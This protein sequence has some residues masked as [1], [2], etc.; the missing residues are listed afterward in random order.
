MISV[1]RAGAKK[2]SEKFGISSTDQ[3]ALKRSKT[4][5]FNFYGAPVVIFISQPKGLGE[6]SILDAG[7]FIQN[8]LLGFHAA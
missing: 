6:W 3:D 1:C 2:R 5:N 8:I 4:A 7:M